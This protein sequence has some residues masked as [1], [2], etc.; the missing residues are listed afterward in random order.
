LSDEGFFK[1]MRRI[2][3]YA[4][5][6]GHRGDVSDP[7]GIVATGILAV[8][9][10]ALNEPPALFPR[11]LIYCRFPLIDGPGNPLWLIRAAVETVACLLRSGM[12][13][14]VY[15]SAGLS[16]SPCVAGAAI[17]VERRLSL[18]Q[19]LKL[20]LRSGPADVS[21]RL[22]SDVRASFALADY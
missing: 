13:T 17:A 16:R 1:K 9:D 6:L 2:D 5:W 20:V 21:L 10:L 15:C 12:P 22:W 14:L 19:G 3:G 7:Q 8:V 11:D 18:D 4:L